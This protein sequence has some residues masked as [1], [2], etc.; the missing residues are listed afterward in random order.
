MARLKIILQSKI[1]IVLSLAFIISYIILFTKIIKYSSSYNDGYNEIIGT[2]IE[3]KIDGD[4][5]S[6]IFK[7]KEKISGT[8]YFKTLEE[9]N[10]VKENI[11]L[12]MSIK[13]FGTINTPSKNTIPN[14][15]NYKKYLYNKKIYKV[16]NVN[17]IEFKDRTNNFFYIIKNIVLKRI[18]NF[19]KCKGYIY[20]F[21]IGES[22]YIENDVYQNY[23]K[24]GVTHLFAVSGMHISFLVAVLNKFLKKLKL[25][26]KNI[27]ILIIS[28][29]GFYMFLIGFTA[30][31][32]RTSLLYILLLF[33]NKLNIKLSNIVVLYL[34]FIF[35][36]LINP[37]YIHDIG[38]VYSFLTSFGLMLFN[39]N[40]NGNYFN[41]LFKTSL[42]AF[43]FS[44]PVTIYNFYEINFST[45][46]NNILIVPLVSLI[47]FPLSLLTFIFPI[48]EGLL[49][50]GFN[51]LE[52]INGF[53]NNFSIDFIMPKINVIFIIIYYFSL[54]KIYKKKNLYLIIITILIIIF[55]TLPF[56]DKNFYIYYL[57]VGQGDS[58][59]IISEQ[60]KNI[61]IIDT[62]GKINYNKE[63][64][65]EKNAN[66]SL[67]N[68]ILSFLKSLG[69]S[70]INN[71]IITHGD[72]DHMGEAI[73]LVN[74]FKVE[75]VIFNCGEFNE[76]E[77]ELIKVLDKKKIP[78]YSCIKEL[79]IDDNKLYFFNNKDYGNENDNSSVIYTE[80]NNYKF[81]FM[82]D[83]G[84][85]VEQNLIEKYNL[86]DI[87]VLKVGHHG[88]KTSSSKNFI[89]E[90][91]PKYSI[92]SVGKNN[93]YGHPNDSVLNNLEASKNYRTDQYGSIMFK[94]KKNKLEIETC[95]P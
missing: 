5:L 85:E 68:N 3:Y 47:L 50:I 82:G 52:Y 74:N 63:A 57:D 83:A 55:K 84:V 14:T 86:K 20:A 87:D 48:L 51:T 78:H 9:K 56:I 2:L 41:K 69:I 13:I 29:L 46:F 67:T 77:Q 11:A 90:V 12:G 88:S 28:F 17:K 61:S 34:V 37:F 95:S 45:I 53:L 58:T 73:N 24:N 75:K 10:Y 32:L 1:F 39:R 64:W 91:N 81:L 16:M 62:G 79:N 76:L 38:F 59:M 70:K 93:R 33:N 7:D 80:L 54:Y 44:L 49:N 30:S 72:Y 26:E 21:I 22:G 36:L 25:K 43:L 89:D 60:K 35:L 40:I 23:Q 6:L 27:N 66:Y 18:N 71:L 8:Y 19:K 92:I 31:V 94:I 65:Q 42:I 15:F 4:K